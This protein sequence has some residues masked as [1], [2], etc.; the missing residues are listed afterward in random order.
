MHRNASAG[1]PA[2]PGG[3]NAMTRTPGLQMQRHL[4]QHSPTLHTAMPLAPTVALQLACACQLAE[5]LHAEPG[6]D[7]VEHSPQASGGIPQL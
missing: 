1:M 2:V 4:I 6:A 7:R 5:W 3:C